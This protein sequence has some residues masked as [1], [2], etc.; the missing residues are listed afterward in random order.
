[1]TNDFSLRCPCCGKR[2][3]LEEFAANSERCWECGNDNV[4]DSYFLDG[5]EIEDIDY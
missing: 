5:I 2:I 4:T 1:M 3:S